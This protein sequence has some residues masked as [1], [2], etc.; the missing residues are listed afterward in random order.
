MF[1][2]VNCEM[3]TEAIIYMSS[4]FYAGHVSVHALRIAAAMP[5]VASSTLI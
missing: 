4:D 5:L 1:D 2:F 3:Q